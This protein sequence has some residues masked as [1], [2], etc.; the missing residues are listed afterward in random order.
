MI[1][2]DFEE[3]LTGMRPRLH[4][5]CARMTGSAIDGEDV[6]QETLIKALNARAAIDG[7]DNVQ[8]WLFRIAHNASLDFLRVRA[9]GATI[10]LTDEMEACADDARSDAVA[11]GFQV[12]LQLPVLQR[13]A[14]ILKDILGHSVEEIASIADSTVPTA[15]SALQR[16]RQRLK[17]LKT[18]ASAPPPIS[19]DDRERLQQY[20]MLFQSGDFDAIRQLLTEDIRLDLTGRIKLQGRKQV[21]SYFTRYAYAGHWRYELGTVEGRLAVLVYDLCGPTLRPAH[22]VLLEWNADGIAAIKDY[23]FTPYVLDGAHWA[24]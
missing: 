13:C 9:R 20:V 23:L 10:P 16:G 7:I 4:R 12:F 22:F 5:Y 15:K 24:D 19:D 21:E 17:K 2:D 18:E 11:L 8:A 1:K 3:L 14:V 6:V